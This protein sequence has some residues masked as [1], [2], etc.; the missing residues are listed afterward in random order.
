LS[1][2]DQLARR[3]CWERFYEYKTSLACPKAF[4]GELR[5]FIDGEAYLPVCRRI[6][7]GEPFPLPRRSVVSKMSSQK[8][9]V[10]YTYPEAENTVLK[11]LTWLLLRRY[12]GLFEANLYSFRPGRTAKDAIRALRAFPGIGGMWAYK[13]DVSNYFNSVPVEKLLPMLSEAL[14]ED[15]RLYAFLAALLAEE[16]ALSGREPVR[17]PKGIMAG[18][19]LS[20]FYA[21]LYLRSLDGHF[22]RRGVPYARYSDDIILFAPDRAGA[23]ALAGEVRAILGE[24]GLGLNPEKEA[25]FPPE[26]GW[27]FLGFRC[28]GGEVDIAPA[29]LEKI[30][31]KMRRKARALMRWR[32]RGGHS[33][34]QAAA[35]F[36]RVFD[37][38]LLDSPPDHELSWKGWF[39][40]LIT[41]A[42]SLRAIDR[43]AQDCLR[44]LISGKRTKARFDV[45]YADLKRLGYRSLVHEYYAF[46]KEED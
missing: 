32:D 42:D 4:A 21:N 35:A 6:E 23:E 44:Y 22:A 10:V 30:K 24:H 29:S 17:E 2:L 12:D 28:R 33:G 40:P 15:R 27:V 25:F 18:T 1:L 11:L 13:A 19:P 37:R 41:T 8:K 45:R 46:Q 14:G 26:E 20:A 9:R 38:K 43:Y 3:E 31:A 5:D 36:L 16:R 39:F 34:E 7:A